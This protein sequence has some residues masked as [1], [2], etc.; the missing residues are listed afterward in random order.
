MHSFTIH[1][2]FI[3]NNLPSLPAGTSLVQA[4]VQLGPEITG[5]A[6]VVRALL[7][8]F[9]ITESN[10]PTDSQVVELVTALARMASEG[11]MLPDVGAVVRA[12]S[13][14]VS[15]Y[16]LTSGIDLTSH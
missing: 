15:H 11:T 13:S 6:E 4:L 3:P 1:I 12:L 9:G 14:F 8:R 2:I 10:P 7:T 5:D 16:G